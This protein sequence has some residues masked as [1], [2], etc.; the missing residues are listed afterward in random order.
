MKSLIKQEVIGI[1]K[2]NDPIGS[3][4]E[5]TFEFYNMTLIMPLLDYMDYISM[6]STYIKDFNNKYPK[7]NYEN[8]EYNRKYHNMKVRGVINSFSRIDEHPI[9]EVDLTKYD[10][11][12]KIDSILYGTGNYIKNF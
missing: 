11:N 9:F 2:E 3:E 5:F 1:S 12:N 4:V 8:K 6:S 7:N 10:R